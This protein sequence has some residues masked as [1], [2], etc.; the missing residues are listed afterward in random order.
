MKRFLVCV[1]LFMC[2]R[3][4]ALPWAEQ[5]LSQ[6]SL[7]EKIGQLFMVTV[8]PTLG[9]ESLRAIETLITRYH[10]G[11]IIIFKGDPAHQVTLLNRYQALS[12]YPLLVGQDCEWGLNERLSDTIKFPK[13]M[14]LGALPD[15][16]LIF[17][18]GKEI[19]RQC[20]LVGVHINFAPVADVNTNPDNPIIGIRSFGADKM[21]VSVKA[22]AFF[23]GLNTSGVLACAKHFPGHGDTSVDSH[24]GLP[25]LLHTRERLEQEEL[26]PFK[27]LIQ[28]NIPAIMTAHVAVP[29]LNDGQMTPATLSPVF[30]KDLLR[31]QL[32]FNGLIITDALDMGAIVANYGAG[33]A[34]C[35]A[36]CAGNDILLCPLE[37][38]QAIEQIKLA[39]NNGR[40]TEQELNDH[41]LRILRAKEK[42]GLDKNRFVISDELCEQLH[43]PEALVL[44]KRVY[45][46]AATLVRDHDNILPIDLEDFTSVAIV[47]IGGQEQT[48]RIVNNENYYFLPVTAQEPE[49]NAVFKELETAQTI[50]VALCNVS[51]R[52]AVF[53]KFIEPSHA[54]TSIFARFNSIHAHVVGVL[55]MSPYYIKLCEKFGTV[56][57]MYEDDPDA[58][59]VML[60]VLQGKQKARGILPIRIM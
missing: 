18:L 26:V 25:I 20:R 59:D 15:D 23:L 3:L 17:E 22:H 12:K 32:V 52:P 48:N 14:T 41:V 13:N 51:E 2:V 21:R 57:C 31:K 16:A 35:E 37:V 45:E 33:I 8:R 28:E 39:I 50:L 19:G 49:I 43:Q 6:L 53:G 54:V 60:Q 44:K 58:W 10:I 27:F 7:D 4:H 38:P 40:I 30:I 24:I 34:A 1:G 5:T 47:Q 9:D 29:A 55:F 36:L 11:N 42:C 46:Q 56:L